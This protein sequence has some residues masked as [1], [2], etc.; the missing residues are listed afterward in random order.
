MNKKKKNKKNTTK[1]YVSPGGGRGHNY[2][3]KHLP[4]CL[5][6]MTIRNLCYYNNTCTF[7]SKNTYL[8]FRIFL[9]CSWVISLFCF[10]FSNLSNLSKPIS[11]VHKNQFE[12]IYQFSASMFNKV[13][14]EMLSHF[15]N[16]LVVIFQ[17]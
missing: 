7:I 14:S 9:S 12:N 2:E 15:V 1:Q 5:L 16:F 6:L 3:D 13:F 8:F 17:F 11:L 4:Y 10:S